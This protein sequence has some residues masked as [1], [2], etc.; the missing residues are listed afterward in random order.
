MAARGSRNIRG[1]GMRRPGWA[2]CGRFAA[3]AAAIVSVLAMSAGGTASAAG[4]GAGSVVSGTATTTTAAQTTTIAACTCASGVTTGCPDCP[5]PTTTTTTT[6]P[7]TTTTTGSGPPSFNLACVLAPGSLN[8]SGTVGITSTFNSTFPVTVRGGETVA[9]LSNSLTFTL[10]SA[11]TTS[12]VDLGANEATISESGY[13]LEF[14]NGTPGTVDLGTVT[15]PAEAIVAGQPATF[16]GAPVSI[17]AVQ[18]NPS[19]AGQNFVA[20]V[21]AAGGITFTIT[22]IGAGSLVVGPVTAACTPPSP[23]PVLASAPILAD[24]GTTSTSSTATTTTSTTTSTPPPPLLPVVS[25]VTPSS[26]GSFSV[27]IIRGSRL[28]RV[29]SVNFGAKHAPIFIALGGG[30]IVALAPSEPAGAVNVTVTTTAGTSATSGADAFTYL[31]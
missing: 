6:P 14:T 8:V 19:A 18:V 22:G 4:S 5:P 15:P 1:A 29:R 24:V 7:T 28:T 17:P 11:W 2:T 31:N 23:A 13:A 10:P 9:T 3:A 21:D 25:S 27:V 26:G 20:S 30:V 12:L 16:F